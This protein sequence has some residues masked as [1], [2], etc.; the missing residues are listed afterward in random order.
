MDHGADFG[1]KNLSM[2]TG[3]EVNEEREHRKQQKKLRIQQV[4]GRWERDH[5]EW[6]RCEVVGWGE[7]V[8]RYIQNHMTASG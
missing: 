8:E 3:F 4:R 7:D 2:C 6:V 5:V 1:W